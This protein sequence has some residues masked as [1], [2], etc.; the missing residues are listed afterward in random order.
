MNEF[1]RE[2][3]KIEE[4]LAR[5]EREGVDLETLMRIEMS[6]ATLPELARSIGQLDYDVHADMITASIVLCREMNSDV[7]LCDLGE[8]GERLPGLKELKGDPG[9]ANVWRFMT[10]LSTVHPVIDFRDCPPGE[11][12]VSPGE[13]LPE[14]EGSWMEYPRP[15]LV[16]KPGRLER[17][18]YETYR[19]RL[20]TSFR[21]YRGESEWGQF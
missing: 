11:P 21:E 18:L 10:Q 3:R 4:A 6:A 13:L 14:R 15:C 2:M 8:T 5:G 16:L 9:F 12:D 7:L 1:A 17:E 19:M 20:S